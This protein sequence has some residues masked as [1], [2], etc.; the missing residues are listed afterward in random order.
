MLLAAS[1]A[2]SALGHAGWRL[3]ICDLT[4]AAVVIVFARDGGA[5]SRVLATPPMQALGR[6]SYSIYLNHLLVVMLAAYGLR[7]VLSATG[8]DGFLRP[9]GVA[10][11]ERLD[12][13]PWGDTALT[14]LAAALIVALSSLTYHFVEEPARQWAKRRA[15]ASGGGERERI[16]PTF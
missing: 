6:W 10:G 13:G 12:F 7:M 15:A 16:A 14:L 5:L 3:L 4:F 11:F 1:L 8:R 9:D 2:M